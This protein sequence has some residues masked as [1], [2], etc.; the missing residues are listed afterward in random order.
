MGIKDIRIIRPDLTG[1]AVAHVF[2]L[3]PGR[4]QGGFQPDYF[5]L[6]GIFR[7]FLQFR[8]FE[9]IGRQMHRPP[10]DPWG[11]TDAHE[12]HFLA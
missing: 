12:N 7:D 2:Q 11:H 4:F 9:N 3:A 5:P 10:G 6:D 1:D 8:D